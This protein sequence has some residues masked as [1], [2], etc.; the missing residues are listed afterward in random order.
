LPYWHTLLELHNIDIIHNEKDVFENVFNTVMD[1]KRKIKDNLKARRDVKMYYHRLE[2][3]VFGVGKGKMSV[4]KVC[5][6]LTV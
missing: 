6:L 5:Y 3:L 1:V 4:L 2:L